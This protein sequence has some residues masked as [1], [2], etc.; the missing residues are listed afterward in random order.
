MTTEQLLFWI[1][2][3][4]GGIVAAWWLSVRPTA[5]FRGVATPVAFLVIVMAAL[6]CMLAVTGQDVSDLTASIQSLRQHY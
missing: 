3:F 5:N 2:A 6:L 4:A 1:I